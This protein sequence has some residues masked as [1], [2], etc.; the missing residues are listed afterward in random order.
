MNPVQNSRLSYKR[1]TNS[2]SSYSAT[3]LGPSFVPTR[4][5]SRVVRQ[6]LSSRAASSPSRVPNLPFLVGRPP[7][8]TRHSRFLQIFI[9]CRTNFR[10]KLSHTDVVSRGFHL[11]LSSVPLL[12]VR[13]C[14]G[15]LFT[16]PVSG[17]VT[18]TSLSF[19]NSLELLT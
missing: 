7:G 2:S 8:D 6:T 19:R 10:V 18:S 16:C 4:Q 13:R 5:K 1:Y 9:R 3:S 15:P 14:S 11:R 12:V 17:S